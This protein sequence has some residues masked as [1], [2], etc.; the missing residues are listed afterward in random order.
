[1]TVGRPLCGRR[2]VLAIANGADHAR[3]GLPRSMRAEHSTEWIRE[4]HWYSDAMLMHLLGAGGVMFHACEL[5]VAWLDDLGRRFGQLPEVIGQGDTTDAWPYSHG[6]IEKRVKTAH[7]LVTWGPTSRTSQIA[8]EGVQLGTHLRLSSAVATDLVL[9]LESK[10][11]FPAA[12]ER[13][14]RGLGTSSAIQVPR[15]TNVRAADLESALRTLSDQLRVE[16]LVVKAPGGLGGFGVEIWTRGDPHAM[17]DLH[18]KMEAD[19]VF[20]SDTVRI[21]ECVRTDTT[22]DISLECHLAREGMIAL[23]RTR[24]L[25]AGTKYVGCVLSGEVLTED[26][27][28]LVHR[29][30]DRLLASGYTGWFDLDGLVDASGGGTYIVEANVRYTGPSVAIAVRDALY[31]TTGSRPS[32]GTLDDVELEIGAG[33][34]TVAQLCHQLSSSNRTVL[35]VAVSSL[36]A[37]PPRACFAVAADDVSDVTGAMRGLLDASPATTNNSARAEALEA[38]ARDLRPRES[39]RSR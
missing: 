12:L 2:E 36:A 3:H 15:G 1:M 13:M 21:E 33:Y 20:A 29:V 38:V 37:D 24:M 5:P 19:D 7:Q 31:E 35:P 27:S 26:Q 17:A 25:V 34:S 8:R 4:C 22:Y 16:Q 10:L 39:R 30:A 23:E 14:M 32:V 18:E 9:A 6:E 28:L 11:Q